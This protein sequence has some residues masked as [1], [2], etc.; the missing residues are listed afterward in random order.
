MDKLQEAMVFLF[1]EQ[2]F[3]ALFLMSFKRVLNAKLP[4]NALAG[5]K[6]DKKN[7]DVTL[8]LSSRFDDLPKEQRAGILQHEAEHIMRLHANRVRRQTLV[9]NI[10]QDIAINQ[11]IPRD[12]LPDGACHLESFQEQYP[13]MRSNMSFE[14]YYEILTKDAKEL[15]RGIYGSGADGFRVDD[16]EFAEDGG[17]VLENIQDMIKEKALRAKDLVGRTDRRG[18]IPDHLTQLINEMGPPKL[19]WKKLLQH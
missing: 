1:N 13:E 9:A 14:Q 17:V 8:M 3:Y 6:V 19:S 7:F 12:W 10:A 5:V 16:H 18:A 2:P 4:Y 11:H 15:Y